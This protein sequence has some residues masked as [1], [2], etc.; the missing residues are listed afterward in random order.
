[1]CTAAY[2]AASAK[3]KIALAEIASCSFLKLR[4][5]VAGVAARLTMDALHKF[6]AAHATFA[7]T[8]GG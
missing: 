8:V 4:Q 5:H 7:I 1:M 2:Y 6:G 3:T